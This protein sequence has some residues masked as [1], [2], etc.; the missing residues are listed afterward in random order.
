MPPTGQMDTVTTAP[1]TER[2]IAA[3]ID[4]IIAI[5]LCFF[6][7]IGWMFGLMY[8]LLRDALPF[9]NGQSF[10]KHLLHLKAIVLPQKEAL[11]TAPE[12]S[13]IRG[14]VMLIPIL[15][16]IDMWFFFSK[17]YRLADKWAQTTVIYS[18]ELE[19]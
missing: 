8:H 10:G 4:M 14:L 13:L 2:I 19:E 15:N 5:G 7:R 16:L 18:N 6:P 12:K 1:S 17:G 11:T 9:L 3:I